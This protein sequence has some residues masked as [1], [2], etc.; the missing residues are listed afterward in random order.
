ML[1]VVDAQNGF[2]NDASRHVIPVIADI[3]DRWQDAD[4]DV[5]FTRYF[6]FAGSP[7]ERLFGW[8]QLQGPPSTEIVEDLA[9]QAHRATAVIDKRI[10]SLFTPSCPTT[11]DG[12]ILTG[13]GAAAS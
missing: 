12:R 3:V 8:C 7:Y 11:G 6:N 2:V 1:V 13:D 5:V 9:A 10:Y 4:Q